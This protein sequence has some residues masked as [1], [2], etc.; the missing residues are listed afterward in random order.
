[1]DVTKN[2]TR[3]QH[4]SLSS[5]ILICTLIY[6]KYVLKV[7]LCNFFPFHKLELEE[8]WEDWNSESA[9]Q[10]EIFFFKP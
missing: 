4:R 8:W 1:M 5:V 7:T 10:I 6:F 2:M 9:K 3:S